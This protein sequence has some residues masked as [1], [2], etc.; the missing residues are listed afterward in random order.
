MLGIFNV[1][2]SPSDIGPGI[3]RHVVEEAGG[4]DKL[5]TFRL[6][7]DLKVHRRRDDIRVRRPVNGRRGFVTIRYT[8]TKN[9]GKDVHSESTG[10]LPLHCMLE[11]DPAIKAYRDQHDLVEFED[12][13]GRHWACP[14]AFAVL[15]D[16]TPLWIEGKYG[17]TAVRD[18]QNFPRLVAGIH[19]DLK[20]K[21]GRIQRAFASAGFTYVVV[22]QSWCR[23]PT[24]V[25]N[26]NLAF[27]AR[28][29]LPDHAERHRLAELLADGP[30]TVSEC[31]RAFP[32][33]VCPEEWVCAAMAHGLIEIDIRAPFGRDSAVTLPS[34]PFW[35]NGRGE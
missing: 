15:S 11:V 8:S 14:D 21:L 24:I 12:E 6:G 35:R 9:S 3:P 22:N 18:A 10:E 33:R 16:G 13:D 20:R 25:R 2:P 31:R 34:E 19:P 4:A 30:T 28:H 32:D 29:N 7:P 23:Q 5:A 1:P 17:A 26:V 27:W